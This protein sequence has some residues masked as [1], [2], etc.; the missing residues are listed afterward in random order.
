MA[1]SSMKKRFNGYFQT[2]LLWSGSLGGLTQFEPEVYPQPTFELVVDRT[3]R[4]GH[5]VERF[6]EMEFNMH[7]FVEVKGVNIQ[8]YRDKITIGELDFIV[9]SNEK[10]YHLEVVYKFYLYDDTVG[11]SNVDHWIGPNRKD[12]LSLKLAKI[13]DYQFP[14]LQAPEVR[15]ELTIRGID[16]TQIDQR[17]FFK[18]QL[19]LPYGKKITISPLN[20]SCI[21]GFYIHQQ[22][23]HS[24]SLHRFF[25]PDKLDWLV[26][27]HPFVPW[28]DYGQIIHEISAL[29]GQKTAPMVW[30]KSPNGEIQKCFVVWW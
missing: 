3:L 6:V 15:E 13:A 26:V 1:N 9:K 24:F 12:A 5:L 19:F 23:V 22:D 30:L 17:V 16:V 18:A 27:P 14:L 20:P 7:P 4:L 29:L 21:A 8:I 2:P 25:L 28:K 11:A 10:W